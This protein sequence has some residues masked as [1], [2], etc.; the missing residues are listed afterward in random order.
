MSSFKDYGLDGSILKSLEEMSFKS[1]SEIQQRTLPLVLQGKDLIG[2]AETGSGKTAACAIPVCNKVD[3]SKPH[4]QALILVPTRELALQYATETQKIGRYKKVST[5]AVYGGADASLQE[6]K[7]K[8][9]VQ[10]CVATPGRLIDFIYSRLIDL[11]HVETLILDEADEML[12]MGFYEDLEFIMQCLTHEHQTLLFSATMPPSIRKIAQGHM[13]DP[14]EVKLNAKKKVPESIMHHFSWCRPQ[15]KERILSTVMARYNPKQAIIFCVS[16]IQCEKVSRFLSKS[17]KEVDYLHGGLGQE[18]RSSITNKFRQGKIRFLVATDVAARGLDFSGVSHVF[19]VQ[20]PKDTETYLHR[21]G[22]TGRFGEEGVCFSLVSN[23]ELGQ[24]RRLTKVLGKK[25][26][27]DNKPP[28]EERKL[29]KKT[30]RNSRR[31]S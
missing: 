5:F 11:T 4:I 16:R 8:H 17:H 1:P 21:S 18:L 10:I 2:L 6:A 19:M 25:V 3:V 27:W 20:L 23:R 30:W 7:L 26:V 15:E 12:S 29:P 22:R 24:A 13:K 14:S 9:A 31:S 28:K